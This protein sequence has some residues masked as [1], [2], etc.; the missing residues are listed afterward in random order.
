MGAGLA[1]AS[2]DRLLALD[3]TR[4]AVA[5]GLRAV[6]S[7]WVAGN[8]RQTPRPVPS[9]RRARPRKTRRRPTAPQYRRSPPTWIDGGNDRPSD[10]A[11][12]AI[13]ATTL[14]LRHLDAKNFL[15]NGDAT[16]FF[17]AAGGLIVR[18]SHRRQ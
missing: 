4:L 1:V 17:E 12:A 8:A 14:A 7:R 11:G 13:D 3:P 10:A 2:R 6:A 15:H 9:P 18:D 16:S 5:R